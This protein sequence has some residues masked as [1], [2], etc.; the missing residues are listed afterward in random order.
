MFNFGPNKLRTPNN[1][2]KTT[3]FE[4]TWFASQYNLQKHMDQL[5]GVR[6]YFKP[7]NN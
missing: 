5:L 6:K 4:E 1:S 3:H 2:E 7:R